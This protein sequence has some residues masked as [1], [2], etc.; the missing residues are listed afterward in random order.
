MS[1]EEKLEKYA[2]ILVKV[3]VNIQPGQPL[4]IGSPSFAKGTNFADDT[5]M[6][7][8]KVA[9]KAYEA[10]A[11]LVSVLWDDNDLTK[12]R[13]NHADPATLDKFEDWRVD[14]MISGMDDGAAVMRIYCSPPDEFSAFD[15][16]LIAKMEGVSSEKMVAYREALRRNESSWLVTS[17]SNEGWAKLVFP[18]DSPEDGVAKLWDAIFK[19]CR[20]DQDDPYQAWMDHLANLLKRGNYLNT[21]DYHALHITGPGTDLEVGLIEKHLWASAG[22]TRPGKTPF[23]ANIP[24][25]EV[26]TTPDKNRVNG[27][28]SA[29][30]P[31]SYAGTII[32]D[33]TLTFENGVVVDAKAGK[34]EK[35]LKEML[36]RDE[37]ASR[38]GEMALV[39]HSSPISQSG[40]LFYN[41]LFDENASCHIALGSAYKMV[42]DAQEIDMDEFYARGGNK[43]MIHV[44]FMIGSDKINIDGVW[45]D[46]SSEPV[47]RNG[48]WAIEV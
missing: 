34:G 7:V 14:S 6:L 35:I 10:G 25:E 20:A 3:G 19:I 21:Q 48:E 37:G 27:T 45:A 22:T 47:L 29:T 43:S 4:F 26:F 17:A 32:E 40:L 1:F 46:G 15:P 38:I 8:H 16:D 36:A 2:E 5:V 9:E 33:F 42:T 44:D 41:T 13:L 28:V 31:L 18:D 12:I 11:S 39:P 23:V 24:T 30:L